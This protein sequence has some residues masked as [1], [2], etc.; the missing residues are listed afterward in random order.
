MASGFGTLLSAFCLFAI[1][2]VNLIVLRSVYRAFVRVRRGEAYVEED[3]N[4][5]LGDR[6]FFARLI[7]PV[8]TMTRRSWHMDLWD[9][10]VFN[11]PW[12]CPSWGT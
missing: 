11:P 9:S 3:F 1:A 4:L 10:C 12:G 6:G 5:L 8:F 2:V 7:R